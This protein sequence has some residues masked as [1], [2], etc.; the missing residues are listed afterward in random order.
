MNDIFIRYVPMDVTIPAVTAEDENGDYNVYINCNLGYEAQEK[1]KEHELNHIRKNHFRSSKAVSVCEDEADGIETKPM[2]LKDWRL[3]AGFKYMQ[4]AVSYLKTD[5][6]KY[7]LCEIDK[8]CK[9][10]DVDY[11]TESFKA[12]IKAQQFRQEL[13]KNNPANR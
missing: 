12:Y 11:Y 13:L 4:D 10:E 6:V 8:H 7:M 2:T 3:L 5:Y 1:G 9:Q